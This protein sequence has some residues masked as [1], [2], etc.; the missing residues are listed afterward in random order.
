MQAYQFYTPLLEGMKVGFYILLLALLGMG[1]WR[2]FW[3]PGT[4]WAGWIHTAVFLNFLVGGIYSGLR[5]L[6]TD[7]VNDMLIR[8]IFALEAWF[9]FACASFYFLILYLFTKPSNRQ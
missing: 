3:K 2:R 9:C 7:P 4:S 8:R 1:I 5:M 6:T